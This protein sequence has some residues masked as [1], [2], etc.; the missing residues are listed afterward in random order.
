MKN[1][2]FFL[3]TFS[4]IFLQ[5]SF[6]T[7]EKLLMFTDPLQFHLKVLIPQCQQQTKHNDGTNSTDEEMLSCLQE[8]VKSI[9]PN[10]Q[11][12]EIIAHSKLQPANENRPYKACQVMQELEEDNI[13]EKKLV[14]KCSD[15][16]LS[17]DWND[18][19][20]IIS[21]NETKRNK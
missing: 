3:L 20:H 17:R 2:L 7:A 21:C 1:K 6:N 12:F 8:T 18:R 9:K 15:N 14:R 4:Q 11:V 13:F 19:V 5:A 16:G 10:I